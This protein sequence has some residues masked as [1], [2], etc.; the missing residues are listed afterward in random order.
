MVGYNRLASLIAALAVKLPLR[1]AREL[2]IGSAA[3]REIG[4][5]VAATRQ[6]QFTSVRAIAA[7]LNE[8]S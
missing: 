6:A 8:V 4:G 3:G 1:C 2:Q 7:Q 5:A